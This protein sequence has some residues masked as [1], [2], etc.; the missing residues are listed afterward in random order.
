M[1]RTDQEESM[2]DLAKS[3]AEVLDL[4]DSQKSVL[5][6]AFMIA[7]S[8]GIAQNAQRVNEQIKNARKG[9]EVS[10]DL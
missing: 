9:E 2:E 7:Y 3:T 5:S 4:E 6:S 1:N 8:L 10:Y